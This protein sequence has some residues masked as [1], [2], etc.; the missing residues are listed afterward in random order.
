MSDTGLNIG[1]RV[2]AR[3]IAEAIRSLGGTATDARRLTDA[4][5]CLADSLSR[6][7]DCGTCKGDGKLPAVSAVP[8]PHCGGNKKIAVPVAKAPSDV[9]RALVID[10]LSRPEPP[11]IDAGEPRDEDAPPE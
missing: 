10:Y 8:C 5:W 1:R 11:W 3:R 6:A 9:T 4:E 7:K 2:K